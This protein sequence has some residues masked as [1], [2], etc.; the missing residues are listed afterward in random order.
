M[1]YTLQARRRY[2][3]AVRKRFLTIFSQA[4]EVKRGPGLETA[5]ILEVT[6]EDGQK[7]IAIFRTVTELEV[8]FIETSKPRK[9]FHKISKTYCNIY[10]NI[11]EALRSQIDAVTSIDSKIIRYTQ[12]LVGFRSFEELLPKVKSAYLSEALETC[13]KQKSFYDRALV[14][15]LSQYIESKNPLLL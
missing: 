3:L 8:E 4:K 11:D 1:T 12:L 15:H 5:R 13:K 7:K 14:K 10:E 6:R 9:R 2:T